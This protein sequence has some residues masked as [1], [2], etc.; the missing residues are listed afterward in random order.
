MLSP[1]QLRAAFPVLRN[2]AN[3]NRPVFLTTAQFHYAFG[4]AISERESAQLHDAWAI[5]APGRP[6]FE[7]AFANLASHSP[8]RVDTGNSA[9][10][11]LLLISGRQ[12][13]AVPDRAT[14]SAFRQYRHSAAVT[15]LKR[16]AGRGHSLTIDSGWREVADIVLDWPAAGGRRQADARAGNRDKPGRP[17]RESGGWRLYLPDPGDR[18]PGSS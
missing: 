18:R 16:L 4:N 7:A 8:T 6:L 5:P 1:A 11:P 2:P 14:S 9:R 13:H 17:A 12:D 10:G 3:R 15:D